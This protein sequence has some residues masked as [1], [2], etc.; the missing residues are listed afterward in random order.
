[1]LAARLQHTTDSL[2]LL[3][4]L[5]P[6][7]VS[8]LSSRMQNT[9]CTSLFFPPPSRVICCTMALHK[10]HPTSAHLIQIVSANFL[11]RL[12]LKGEGESGSDVQSATATPSIATGSHCAT[13]S[14][15]QSLLHYY[16]ATSLSRCSSHQP[17]R[18]L[19]F[20]S[21]HCNYCCIFSFPPCCTA[22][23]T[24]NLRSSPS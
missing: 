7:P 9:L 19:A 3:I 20:T 10:K 22:H 4:C 14:K 24:L 6:R 21:F 23:N 2:C 13:T 16:T 8:S 18:H 12:R 1:M 11:Q 15:L 17:R 5:Q